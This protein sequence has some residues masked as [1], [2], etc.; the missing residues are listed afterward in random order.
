MGYYGLLH[1][2]EMTQCESDHMVRF[3]DV[4]FGRNKQKVVII[5]RSSKTHSTNA[6]PQVVKITGV[7]EKTDKHYQDIPKYCPVTYS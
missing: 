7:E 6:A 2:G 3:R 5:P 1:I 4:Y